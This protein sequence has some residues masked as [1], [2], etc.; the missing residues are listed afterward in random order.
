MGGTLAAIEKGFI[1]SEIQ[2]AAYSYQQ[3]VE[4]GETIVVGAIFKRIF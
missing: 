3:S 4:R 1:Q 2:N